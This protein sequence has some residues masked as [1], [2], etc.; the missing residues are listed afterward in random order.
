MFSGKK[1]EARFTYSWV[2][3]LVASELITRSKVLLLPNLR[4]WII[5]KG[6]LYTLTML[7]IAP[8]RIFSKIPV[9]IPWSSETYYKLYK[10]YLR[11]TE[12]FNT[13][14]E[15]PCRICL[16]DNIKRACA[17]WKKGLQ[18]SECANGCEND[19]GWDIE[20]CKNCKDKK[21]LGLAACL[22]RLSRKNKKWL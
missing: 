4:K 1:F 16:N 19:I 14:N 12:T 3:K 13:H 17:M 6:V 5:Q 2:Y 18:A 11:F 8:W 20:P 21:K 10:L 7:L 9:K 22:Q 15:V